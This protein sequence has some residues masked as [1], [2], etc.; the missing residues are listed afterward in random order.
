M[1]HRRSDCEAAA[2]MLGIPFRGNAGLNDW[3]DGSIC[4]GDEYFQENSHGVVRTNGAYDCGLVNGQ[5]SI[6]TSEQEC[7]DAAA[8]AGLPWGGNAGLDHWKD[9]CI[10]N[11][12]HAFW[13]GLSEGG[14]VY[15]HGPH[16]G[17]SL[18][19]GP[20][21]ANAPQFVSA[22]AGLE[23]K[24]GPSHPKK[25]NWCVSGNGVSAD[26]RKQY[27]SNSLGCAGT[28]KWS[29]AVVCAKTCCEVDAGEI[30]L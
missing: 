3:M 13:V 29:N 23:N 24:R 21:H 20:H 18:C 5:S 7:R 28:H 1:F 10:V 14:D 11:V 27:N 30:Q 15:T 17:G 4:I 12:G 19:R 22:C 2:G 25:P 16:T 6:M 9:G 26:F 8:S